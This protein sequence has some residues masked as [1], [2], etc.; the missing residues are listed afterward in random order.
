MITVKQV[1]DTGFEL[2]N[3]DRIITG[4]LK[5]VSK[6]VYNLHRNPNY[7]KYYDDRLIDCFEYR[8]MRHDIDLNDG[9][10]VDVIYSSGVESTQD[11]KLVNWHSVKQWRPSMKNWKV[12][13]PEE[14]EALDAI[15]QADSEEWNGE[16][17]PPV[18]VECEMTFNGKSQTITTLYYDDHK[19]GMIMFYHVDSGKS[20]ASDYD[21]CLV[22]NCI[23]R[24]PETQ[25]QREDR[26]RLE[27][28]YELYV[29]AQVALDGDVIEYSDFIKESRQMR[30]AL[31][32]VDKTG[33]RKESK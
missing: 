3:N 18:G 17:L 1:K 33:Y 5:K 22:E 29:T 13:T 15:A 24:K 10:I 31:A 26:E 23:F 2:T 11:S 30:G 4:K 7:N 32:I 27:S 20:V 16:G 8:S 14:S 25:Q 28:A 12:E 6:R 9:M 19:S 21:W